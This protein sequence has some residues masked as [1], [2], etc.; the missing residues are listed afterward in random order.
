MR[1]SIL[2]FN[3]SKAI[4]NNLKVDDLLLLQYIMQANAEPN[5]FHILD[6]TETC[7]VWLSHI[8]IQE[9]LPILGITE[10]TLK[11]KLSKLKTSGFINSK[12]VANKS[13]RGT[14]TYYCIT[15]KTMSLLNDVE[16]TT[17]FSSDVETGPRHLKVTSNNK[18]NNDIK[19][20]TVISK[21]ITEQSSN[22]SSEIDLEFGK[23]KKSKPNLYQQCLSIINDYTE[24]NNIRKLLTDYLDL[25]LEKMRNE[26][27]VLY[28]NQFKGMMKHLSDLVA[29]KNGKL[30]DIISQSISKGYIGFFPANYNNY[31]SGKNVTYRL[32]KQKIAKDEDKAR[33]ENGN[34]I[35]F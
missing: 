28:A 29:N 32:P 13:A 15:E 4:E 26:N 20:N 25:L 14:R 12:S 9:D 18:L 35:V 33:D 31:S 11:N 3:Q 27:K 21:D 30:E 6:E 17:S 34:Y 8:K 23:P 24:D 22:N 2:N 10:G 19:L 1:Y 16:K 7:Y 5:M